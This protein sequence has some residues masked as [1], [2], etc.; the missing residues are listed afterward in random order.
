MKPEEVSRGFMPGV[1]FVLLIIGSLGGGAALFWSLFMSGLDIG[2]PL[3]RFLPVPFIIM[4]VL[5]AVMMGGRN[6]V[7]AMQQ[8]ALAS[9][10]HRPG[11]KVA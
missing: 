3:V 5:G 4:Q 1:G 8:E 11:P 6:Q 10:V 7:E 2:D 9:A